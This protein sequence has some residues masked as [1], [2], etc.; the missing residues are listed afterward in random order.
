MRTLFSLTLFS[1]FSF[2]LA[3]APGGPAEDA[4]VT[5]DAGAVDDAGVADDAGGADDA[6]APEADAGPDGPLAGF[7]ELSGDCRVLDS[8]LSD[9]APHFFEGAIDF[10]T[11]PF[12]DPADVPLLTAGGQEILSDG[13]AGGSSLESEIFAFEVLA[14]CEGAALLKTE[15][16]I[17]YTDDMGKITDL[18]I[19][20]DGAKIGVSVT[21]ALAF[22]FDDPYTVMQATDLLTDKLQGVLDST[23]NVAAA[24]AW[25]KQILSVIAYTPAHVVSLRSAWDALDA[26]LKAD[27]IV[28][29]TASNGDDAF[30]Y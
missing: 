12:D 30:L 23:A 10:G 25:D 13:N 7:G 17:D 3:C 21:R 22:P 2:F 24:D 27:T 1:S 16:E 19:D 18:L 9:A 8:E 20:I 15:T 28:Y 29:V 14:R 5:G 11:D 4:G 26:S 6:G